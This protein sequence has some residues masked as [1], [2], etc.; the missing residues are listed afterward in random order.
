MLPRGFFKNL[1]AG[2]IGSTF[3]LVAISLFFL[4]T[5]GGRGSSFGGYF[6]RHQAAWVLV[7]IVA[8]LLGFTL[9]YKLWERFSWLLYIVNIALLLGLLLFGSRTKGAESWFS[10]GFARFQPSEIAKILFIMTFAGFLTRYRYEINRLPVLLLALGQFFLPFGLILLQPDMGTALVF[11]AIF[12]GMLYVSGI[13]GFTYFLTLFVFISAGIA[14]IPFFIKGYQFARLT[15]F[16]AP[17]RDPLG[18]G[19]QLI[20]S[21]IA[22][23]S[24][25][26]LGKGIFN[27]TQS[28]LG[29][30][31][32]S[33]SDFIF[34][35]ICEQAGFIGGAIVIIL[36]A[37]QLSR[38]V[39]IGSHSEDL[40]AM[41]IAAGVFCMFAFQAV[42]NIGMTVGLCPITG[43]PLPFVSYG[44]S[45]LMTSSLAVG[46]L[47][48]I[49]IRR[50]KIMFV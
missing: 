46:L 4:Y 19:Y 44:G 43:V 31:P 36:I 5:L 12:F 38:I 23:G 29:F 15:S 6:F 27:G 35:T 39:S 45:S 40:Y 34:A 30:L 16:L 7:A 28:S 9:N 8:G 22:I 37:W 14:A 17:E 47:L 33:E 3:L 21:K 2:L 11:M 49:C 26:L 25:G 18:T 48:N 20:Q 1:D 10:L 13:D 32:T 50:R 24:G 41:F 42:V